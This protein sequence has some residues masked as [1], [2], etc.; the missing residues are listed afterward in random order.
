MSCTWD[1]PDCKAIDYKD[2]TCNLYDVNDR[3]TLVTAPGTE[4]YYTITCD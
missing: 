4:H 1:Y 2:K 3:E